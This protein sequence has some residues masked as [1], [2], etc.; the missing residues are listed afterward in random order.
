MTAED[1]A[2]RLAAARSGYQ[3]VSYR[4]VALPLFKVDLELLVLEKKKLPPIQEYV[5]RAVERGLTDTAASPAC[6]ASRR[7]SCEHERRVL[8]STDNLVAG[9]RPRRRPLP[10]A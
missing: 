10:T 4:E 7:R 1:V 8:L 9:R 3:L 6:S 5:L 2:R